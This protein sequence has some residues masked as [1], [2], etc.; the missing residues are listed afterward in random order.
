MIEVIEMVEAGNG[1]MLALSFPSGEFFF[2]ISGTQYQ[3]LQTSMQWRWAKRNRLNRKPAKQFLG[4]D[5]N[6]KTLNI[7]IYP[8]NRQDLYQFDTMKQFADQGKPGRLVGGTPSGGADLG[9]WC[10]EKLDRTDQYFM[11]NG[12]PL[13]IKGTLTISEYGEDEY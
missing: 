9:L 3:Q 1:V 11:A 13:E 2:S 12:I 8:Q 6:T 10:I 7:T 4:P 5:S